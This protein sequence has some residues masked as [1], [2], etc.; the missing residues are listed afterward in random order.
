MMQRWMGLPG[1]PVWAMPALCL[2]I[3][4]L[5][6]TSHAQAMAGMKAGKWP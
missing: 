3:A 1:S 5:R 2:Q 4:W 6:L